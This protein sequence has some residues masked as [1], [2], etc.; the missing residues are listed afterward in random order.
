MLREAMRELVVQDN[1]EYSAR[2]R[3]DLEIA[4]RHAHTPN[5][6]EPIHQQFLLHK[7]R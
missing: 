3:A 6:A 2:L 4:F 1:Q 7:G 5:V